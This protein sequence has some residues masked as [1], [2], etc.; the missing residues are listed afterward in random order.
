MVTTTIT[1]KIVTVNRLA[2]TST[3]WSNV[4]NFFIT[5][6]L[7]L[8]KGLGSGFQRGGDLYQPLCDTIQKEYGD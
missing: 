2:C 6:I 7:V 8:K 3:L 1:A 4:L 5:W